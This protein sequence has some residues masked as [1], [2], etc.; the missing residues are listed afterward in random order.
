M[1]YL[2]FIFLLTAITHMWK[3]NEKT[4]Y[5]EKVDLHLFFIAL[6]FI[7]CWVMVFSDYLV[8]TFKKQ[9]CRG[10]NCSVYFVSK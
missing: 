7:R 8:A 10:V 1:F 2:G 5:S 4:N 3:I 6:G 9:P